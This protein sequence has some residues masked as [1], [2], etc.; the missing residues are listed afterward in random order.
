[1][2][3]PQKQ[4]RGIWLFRKIFGEFPATGNF[5]P[6]PIRI[7]HGM[8]ARERLSEWHRARRLDTGGASSR[9]KQPKR[10]PVL[11]FSVEKTSCNPAKQSHNP[12]QS[13]IYG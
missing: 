12:G 2:P 5:S 8:A 9:A 10:T 7:T 1:M 13:I 6:T 11:I 3:R 4:F